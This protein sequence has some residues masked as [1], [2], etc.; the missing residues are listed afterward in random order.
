MAPRRR[1]GGASTM[2]R[3]PFMFLL[4]FIRLNPSS[5]T[6]MYSYSLPMDSNTLT[7]ITFYIM[8]H[9]IQYLPVK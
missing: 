8:L 1:D 4:F 7:Y 9:L 5:S 6:E 3:W 2:A